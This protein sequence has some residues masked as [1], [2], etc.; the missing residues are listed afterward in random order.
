MYPCWYCAVSYPSAMSHSTTGF[1]HSDKVLLFGVVRKVARPKIIGSAYGKIFFVKKHYMH[2]VIHLLQVKS[3][4]LGILE[5]TC[6]MKMRY[7]FLH[8][9]EVKLS[10]ACSLSCDEL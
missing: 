5:M 1:Q 10:I 3:G 8:A 2:K 4:R 6:C 9:V 7:H